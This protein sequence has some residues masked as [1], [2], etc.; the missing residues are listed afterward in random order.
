MA[1]LDDDYGYIDP[2]T[3]SP[4]STAL[5]YGG[6]AALISVIIGLVV[7][8][9]GL[10]DYEAAAA[11]ETD[12]ISTMVQLLSYVIWAGAVY[13]AIKFHRDEQLGGY[14]TFGRGFYTG[15]ATSLVMGAISAVWTFIF[16]S[17]IAPEI[18]DIMREAALNNMPEDQAE[19][20][21]GI[22]DTMMSPAVMT[23]SVFVATIVIGS[24]ISVIASAIMKKDHPAA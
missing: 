11:G 8:L 19:Q 24:I 2:S 20:A 13:L 5:R 6:L 7:H 10:Q 16:F 22:M 18:L 12:P 9:A 1:T 3:V 4:W 23:G 14:I 21:E 15:F 17:M